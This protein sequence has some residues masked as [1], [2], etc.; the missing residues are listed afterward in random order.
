MCIP[1]ESATNLFPWHTVVS[2]APC[3]L[4]TSQQ[5]PPS[6]AKNCTNPASL[7]H[8]QWL[9]S[10]QANPSMMLISSKG[11]LPTLINS[12]SSQQLVSPAV[13][14]PF[15]C[16]MPAAVHSLKPGLSITIV[17]DSVAQELFMLVLTLLFG[18][19]AWAPSN[20]VYGQLPELTRL[21]LGYRQR[22]FDSGDRFPNRMRFLWAG[23]TQL[24][25]NNMGAKVMQDGSWRQNRF[26]DFIKGASVV[27]LG[28]AMHD[29]VLY[30]HGGENTTFTYEQDVYD[31]ISIA[32]QADDK[33]TV[34]MWM[35]ASALLRKKKYA[36]DAGGNPAMEALNEIARG[37][38]ARMNSP[39]AH[40]LDFN[41]RRH[42]GD[43]DGD[44]RHCVLNYAF[45][46][47]REFGL[48]CMSRAM[49]VVAAIE[50]VS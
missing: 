35:S 50:A 11:S 12:S 13:W 25:Q 28:S 45:E 8:G 42:G 40:Y 32:L 19:E 27:L 4:V 1:P 30:G 14:S 44:G 31:M 43:A 34:V 16:S 21:R 7:F 17:G 38:I 2:T 26:L 29:A 15:A 5:S 23:H 33:N 22:M 9:V 18:R 37:V 46:S 48:T 20:N 36:C 10:P 24:G 3:D 47:N 41:Q 39:R 49:A 6:L